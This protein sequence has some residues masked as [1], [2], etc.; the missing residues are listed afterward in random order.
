MIITKQE[1]PLNEGL[2]LLCTP[3]ENKLKESKLV[4]QDSN[5]RKSIKHLM[6]KDNLWKDYRIIKSNCHGVC[7]KDLLSILVCGIGKNK[8]NKTILCPPS[9]KPQ[10]ILESC[11]QI[12]KVNY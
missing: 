6:I 5:I 12:M 2:F 8:Q 1:S 11:L 7:P 10:Q 3:C 4:N 9:S